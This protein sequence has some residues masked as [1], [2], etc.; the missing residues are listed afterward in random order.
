MLDL[1]LMTQM[2]ATPPYVGAKCLKAMNKTT[3]DNDWCFED[4]T[5]ECY[6]ALCVG[7][8]LAQSKKASQRRRHFS[9]NQCN[10]E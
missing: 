7:A 3:L 1:T 9:W 8:T 10:E 2:G 6:E 4:T 5:I